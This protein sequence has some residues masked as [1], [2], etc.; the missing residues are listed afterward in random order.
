MKHRT[1]VLDKARLFQQ[2][3]QSFLISLEDLPW[4]TVHKR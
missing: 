1:S 4:L 3:A 2:N